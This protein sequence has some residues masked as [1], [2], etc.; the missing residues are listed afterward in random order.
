LALASDAIVIGFQ[1]D[2]DAAARRLAEAEGVEVKRYKIIYNLI[3]DIELAL[4]GLYEPI[5]ED[6]VMGHA[7]VRATFKLGNK[8]A[9]AG[10]Y[11]IDG[12]I[13]R[14]AQIRVVRDRK[15]LYTDTIASLRRFT[16]DVDEVS[17]GYECGIVLEHFKDFVE[18]DILEA[19]VKE[20]IN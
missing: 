7:E 18:G 5:Y 17:T 13:N 2:V 19:F 20:R 1:V 16:E 3:E 8:G 10:C 12:K 14:K 11:V 6:R 4:S 15:L 9:V